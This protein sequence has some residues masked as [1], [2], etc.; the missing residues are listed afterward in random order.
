MKHQNI[1]ALLKGAQQMVIDGQVVFIAKNQPT[2]SDVH[3][4]TPL[5]SISVAFMQNA[6]NFV[7]DR[8]FP[9]VPVAKQSDRYYTYD[10]GF[11]NR[12][13]MQKRAPGTET[14][15]IGYAVDNT[16][17]YYCDVWGVHFDVHDQIRANADT[18]IS[19][20]R[21]ATN[22]VSQQA[23]LRKEK[24]WVANYFTT[25]VWTFNRN[26]VASSPVAGTS[27][28]QWN[29]AN[30]DPIK[31]VKDAKREI[32][33]ST[34]FEPNKLTIG[35]ATYDA[36]TLHPDIIDRI[37]YGGQS[38]SGSGNPA[39]VNVVTLA[40]LFE[41]E[42]VLVCNAIENTAMEGIA[43]AHAFIAGKH[44]LL[45][46]SPASPGLQVPSA[47]Y[48]FSWT[49][50]LGASALGGRISKFRMEPLKSDRV[51]LELAFQQKVIAADLG[52]FWNGIVA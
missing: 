30:S 2:A 33:Q 49:G 9:N 20:D 25:G 46:Y 1:E 26:G 18:V 45:T 41:V 5:T 13:E 23:L 38:A 51:E 14:K 31:D 32:A 40:M 48:T 47:A 36:L 16:P 34:G 8:V 29:D 12:A 19:P 50:Y 24:S 3:V 22:L 44:A 35:R 15:G 7:A 21:D 43:N 10:R 11:F 27:V 52:W 17:S 39:R 37:K 28:L 6:A 42:E 4:N